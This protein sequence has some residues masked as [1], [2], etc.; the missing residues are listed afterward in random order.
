MTKRNKKPALIEQEVF[1]PFKPTM[2]YNVYCHNDGSDSFHYRELHSHPYLP[3]RL[4]RWDW[5]KEDWVPCFYNNG[6]ALL[7]ACESTL[8]KYDFKLVARNVRFN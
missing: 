7:A 8:T 6:I 4:E 2:L 3:N 1:K 5:D